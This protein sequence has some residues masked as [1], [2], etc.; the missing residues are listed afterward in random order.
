MNQIQ[1]ERKIVG[2]SK[3]Q[4]GQPRHLKIKKDL[5]LSEPT[6][7]SRAKKGSA[8]S[9]GGYA[10]SQALRLAG[11]LVLTRLLLREAF[12]LMVIVN[13]FIIGLSLFSDIGIGP[14]L[15]QNKRGRES[16]FFNTAWTMQV[17]RG[18]GLW[19]VTCLLAVPVAIFYE[20]PVLRFILP[21]AG[22]S[23]V[24]SGFRSTRIILLNRELSLARPVALELT[25]Q[26]SA[27]IIMVTWAIISPSIWA[28][29]AGGLTHQFVYTL[30][31]HTALPGDSNRFHWEPKAVKE[32]VTFGRWIFLST[33]LMFLAKE[34]DSA[35]FGKLISMTELGIYAIASMIATMPAI[36]LGRLNSTIMFPL[37]SR[38]FADGSHLNDIYRTVRWPMLLVGGWIL[39]GLLG[40]GPTIIKL[41]YPDTYLDAGWMLQIRIVGIWFGVILEG[42]NGAALLAR[43]QPYWTAAGSGAKLA[44]L[45]LFFPLGFWMGGFPGALFGVVIS[46]F[47]RYI[48]SRYA[49]YR[50]G[51]HGF[52]QDFSLTILV[53]VSSAVAWLVAKQVRIA[54]WNIFIETIIVFLVT[55]TMW[56]PFSWSQIKTHFCHNRCS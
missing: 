43:A 1:L 6:M 56:L 20:E 52:T 28:L 4:R 26:A 53:A 25:S 27:L 31:S 39:S 22:L 37:Y 32:L 19:L 48:I 47:C 29:V 24:L 36:A 11:N 13:V 14:S 35:I 54:E 33:S 9:L 46:E 7:T 30:L 41:L 23:A 40:G 34:T 18:I 16:S 45:L 3:K 21:V 38:M 17:W 51:L 12:G 49:S 44:G 50:A 42:T 15:I 10:A 2:E 55:T 5:S 8:I